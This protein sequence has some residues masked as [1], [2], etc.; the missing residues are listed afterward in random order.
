MRYLVISLLLSLFALLVVADGSGFQVK[1]GVK[2]RKKVSAT[3]TNQPSFHRPKSAF[4]KRIRRKKPD[5]KIPF[6]TSKVFGF[7]KQ[8]SDFEGRSNTYI[9]AC[10]MI[11]Q[12]LSFFP[13]VGNP[14]TQLNF[15]IVG[16]SILLI[17]TIFNQYLFDL[18]RKEILKK[19]EM[20]RIVKDQHDRSKALNVLTKS[21]G[22]DI[23]SV[24]GNANG[25]SGI[26][27]VSTG[28]SI[29]DYDISE[30]NGLIKG[31]IMELLSTL[32]FHYFTQSTLTL[33][34]TPLSG[35]SRL[36]SSPLVRIHF[37]GNKSLG[38]YA[39]PFKMTSMTDRVVD[40]LRVQSTVETANPEDSS[41][42]IVTNCNAYDEEESGLVEADSSD[43]DDDRN[44]I[45]LDS[46]DGDC[47]GVG[48]GDG[49]Q[50]AEVETY[51]EEMN[52]KELRNDDLLSD[53]ID[54]LSQPILR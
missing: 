38:Q 4:W 37:C 8:L 15:K 27:N 17:Y 28:P 6:S 10:S 20:T 18:L 41:N 45:A 12:C 19:N 40:W 1:S 2:P 29:R 52:G 23:F 24:L 11:G 44:D 48:Y 13:A 14:P 22:Y 47:D 9:Q 26:T 16:R 25:L 3:R 39:R 7:I 53:W 50:E 36:L 46:D 42:E 43:D 51:G 30:L 33:F 31:N 35:L 32:Y 54:E 49:T 5:R 21:L 34:L